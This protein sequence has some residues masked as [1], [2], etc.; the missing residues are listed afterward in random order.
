MFG[1][2]TGRHRLPATPMGRVV[3][4]LPELAVAKDQLLPFVVAHYA[5]G[6]AT[7]AVRFGL[8]DGGGAIREAV[9]GRRE[10]VISIMLVFVSPCRTFVFDAGR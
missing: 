5:H 7:G 1:V 6:V 9:G 8:L 10:L 3:V 4:G 2:C